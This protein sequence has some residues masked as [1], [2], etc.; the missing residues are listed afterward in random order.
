MDRK[1]RR[2]EAML[3]AFEI[4]SKRMDEI[5]PGW[6]LVPGVMRRVKDAARKAARNEESRDAEMG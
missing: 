4:M 3:S 5:A 1:K 6:R 2:R